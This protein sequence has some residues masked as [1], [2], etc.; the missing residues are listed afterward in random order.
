MMSDSSDSERGLLPVHSI[1]EPVNT[2]I[3]ISCYRE[4]HRLQRVLRVYLKALSLADSEGNGIS[5]RLAILRLHDHKGTLV[6]RWKGVIE[7]GRF[8]KYVDAAWADEGE[9]AISHEDPEG[10][11]I[12]YDLLGMKK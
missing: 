1:D 4:T 8:G 12:I 6:A 9:C 5:F 2:E 3:A 11:E 7:Y 10:N